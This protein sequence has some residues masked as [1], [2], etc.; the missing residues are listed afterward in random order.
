MRFYFQAESDKEAMMHPFHG[1]LLIGGMALKDLEGEL[2][3]EAPDQDSGD[4]TLSGKVNLQ[5]QAQEL[6]EVGRTYRL[7]LDDGRAGQIVV[8]NVV[9]QPDRLVAEFCANSKPR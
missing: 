5:A 1:Q 2:E 7:L 9:Q 3:Q 6:V 8:N 4:W